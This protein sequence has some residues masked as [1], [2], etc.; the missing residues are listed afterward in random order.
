MLNNNLYNKTGI[1]VNKND[2]ELLKSLG[3]GAHGKVLLCKHKKTNI[4]YAMKV[5]KK[6]NI[7][8]KN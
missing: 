3:R 7:I 8:Q 5:L 2:F 1:R 4:I 6:S